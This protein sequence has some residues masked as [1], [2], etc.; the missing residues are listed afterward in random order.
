MIGDVD[1]DDDVVDDKID[2]NDCVITTDGSQYFLSY[3]GKR[4]GN[5]YN[6]FDDAMDAVKAWRDANNNKNSVW[7]IDQYG[8]VRDITDD[9]DE[10]GDDDKSEQPASVEDEFLISEI[11][12]I[13]KNAKKLAVEYIK[14]K[15]SHKLESLNE[16]EDMLDEA[17][18]GD[19]FSKAG[20][21]KVF[22]KAKEI[23]TGKQIDTLLQNQPEIARDVEEAKSILST[24]DVDKWKEFKV[25]ARKN[26]VLVMLL[27]KLLGIGSPLFAQDYTATVPDNL[28]AKIEMVKKDGDQTPKAGIK[29][30]TQA[31]A[32]STLAKIIPSDKVSSSDGGKTYTYKK[33]TKGEKGVMNFQFS[34]RGGDKVGPSIDINNKKVEADYKEIEKKFQFI[35]E[36]IQKLGEITP[37]QF[38][39][40]FGK[41]KSD[42]EARF[43]DSELS[44]TNQGIVFTHKFLDNDNIAQSNYKTTTGEII[45]KGD[46]IPQGTTVVDLLGAKIGE[47]GKETPGRVEEKQVVGVTNKKVTINKNSL[48]NIPQKRVEKVNELENALTKAGLD[49]ETDGN[50]IVINEQGFFIDAS[51]AKE[52]LAEL[53]NWAKTSLGVDNM[54]SFSGQEAAQGQ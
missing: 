20:L 49:I 41:I 38:K 52:T 12:K 22:N 21:S 32:D 36:E 34:A 3:K 31:V 44:L 17:A 1:F 15:Y 25:K 14:E 46:R 37:E 23:F 33:E 2:T 53:N 43:A 35:K 54:F 19:I 6:A 27:L 10:L 26:I 24:G 39:E 29:G 40:D 5:P 42:F 28:K 45:K 48:S 51:T 18:L 4:L 30:D 8:E 9:F 50:Y 47:Q 7:F 13:S 11:E 16:N